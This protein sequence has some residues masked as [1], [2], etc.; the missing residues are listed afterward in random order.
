MT[1]R[2]NKMIRELELHRLA[3]GTVNRLSTTAQY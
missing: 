2:R 1:P 3:T